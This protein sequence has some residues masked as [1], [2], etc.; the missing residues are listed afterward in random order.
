MYERQG[1]PEAYTQLSARGAKI[2][3]IEVDGDG[4]VVDRSLAQ[5]DLV[6]TTPSNQFPTTVRMPTQRRKQLI[7]AAEQHDFLII[8]D[9]FE[10]EVNFI[11]QDVPALK[12][13]FYSER[14]IYLSSFSSTI[15]PGLRIGFMVAAEPL[16]Q[17]AKQLQRKNH[18]YPPQNNCQTLALFLGLGHYD[19]LIQKLLKSLREKWLTME[20]ALNYYFP[21]SG[22]VPS[23]SGSAFWV[24]YSSEFDADKLALIAQQQGILINSGSQYYFNGQ[25]RNGFR[26][27]FN[28]IDAEHIREG[29]LRLS[30]ITK[31]LL[32]PIHI[33]NMKGEP[34]CGKEI[35][36]KLTQHTLVTSDCFNIPYYNT[37]LADGTMV[38]ISE[39]P[40]D[41]DEGRWWVEENKMCYQW[42][43]WQFSEVRK[44]TLVL[45]GNQLFRF[46][47]DGFCVS[48]GTLYAKPIRQ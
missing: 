10:H 19:A 25:Q 30:K 35:T 32:P 28:S 2:H 23:L 18:S 5:C 17:L 37:F 11:E 31:Q 24:N 41:K 3:P 1:Y 16:I 21:Q 27:S 39:R 14:V 12:G 48:E 40:N 15:A 44:L 13:E 22:V 26:L 20:K 34:L 47:D 38:G 33:D 43:T 45:N 4:L 42:N 9:D 6:Y 8:E 7:E 36:R 29:I 46:D